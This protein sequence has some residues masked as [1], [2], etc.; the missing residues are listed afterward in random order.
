MWAL[1]CCYVIDENNNCQ[2]LVTSD[3]AFVPGATR[4]FQ[5]T[6]EMQNSHKEIHF[7]NRNNQK[8]I[9]ILVDAPD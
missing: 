8:V 2:L 1:L 4:A 5:N 7:L 6:K 3:S 9:N